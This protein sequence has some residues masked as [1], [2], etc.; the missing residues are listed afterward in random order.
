MTSSSSSKFADPA[1]Y[2]VLSEREVLD[3]ESWAHVAPVG[4]QLFVRGQDSLVAMEWK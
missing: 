1:E 4:D 3:G 2:K